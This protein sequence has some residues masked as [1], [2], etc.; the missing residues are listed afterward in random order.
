VHAASARAAFARGGV[1]DH[2][3]LLRVYQ[4]WAES[5]FSRAWCREHFVQDRSMKRARD[6]REQLEGLCARVE[7]EV[8]SVLDAREGS[9]AE[10][11]AA[12]GSETARASDG[13]AETIARAVCAGFFAHAASLQKNGSYRTTKHG[14]SVA[15]HPGSALFQADPPPEWVLYHE[16]VFTSKEFMRQVLPIQRR[17]LTETASHFYKAAEIEGGASGRRMPSSKGRARGKAARG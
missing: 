7:I 6:V 14:H 17:W 3:A 9:P 12:E 1:G 15:V 16:L 8:V 5:G 4:G 10:F 13:G 11:G 2:I